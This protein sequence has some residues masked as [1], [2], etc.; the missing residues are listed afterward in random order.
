[1]HKSPHCPENFGDWKIQQSWNSIYE[2]LPLKKKKKK[3]SRHTQ[4]LCEE[5]SACIY[6]Y[7]FVIFKY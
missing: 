2:K 5:V 7:N 1:M 6:I 4:Y 3:V